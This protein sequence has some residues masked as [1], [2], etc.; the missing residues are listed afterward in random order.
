[1]PRQ[2]RIIQ[3]FLGFVLVLGFSTARSVEPPVTVQV[4]W[5]GTIRISKTKPSL[6][7]GA[8]RDMRRN[9]PLHDKIFKAVA[10]LGADDVRYAGGGYVYPHFGVPE[11]DP[12]SGTK[13]SWDFSYVD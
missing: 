1:M 4:R 7:L 13:T 5:D 10:G 3:F 11:L 2:K 6:L 12:P 9:S 8:W